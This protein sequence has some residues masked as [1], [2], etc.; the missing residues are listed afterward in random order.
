MLAINTRRQMQMSEDGVRFPYGLKLTDW[1]I[2]SGIGLFCLFS[3]IKYLPSNVL[4]ELINLKMNNV[5]FRVLFY[6]VL[7]LIIVIISIYNLSIIL[8]KGKNYVCFSTNGFDIA[9]QGLKQKITHISFDSISRLILQKRK[10]KKFLA[11]QTNKKNHSF[12]AQKFDNLSD[13]DH[14][15]QVLSNKAN[16]QI[17]DKTKFFNFKK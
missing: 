3:L 4:N 13:F 6:T 8:I 10:G 7:S 5:D 16:I 9:N 2:F 11:V 15:C 17:E 12:A 14:F 1:I